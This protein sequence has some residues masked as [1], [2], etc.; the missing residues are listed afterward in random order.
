MNGWTFKRASRLD[1]KAVETHAQTADLRSRKSASAA[2]VVTALDR[3][4]D[5]VGC[6]EG[7]PHD[8]ASNPEHL[9]GLG[10]R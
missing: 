9:A 6:F 5:L 4:G 8:L 3:A 7:G 2:A 10:C 1:A